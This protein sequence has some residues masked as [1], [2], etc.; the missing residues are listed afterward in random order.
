MVT[1][2]GDDMRLYLDGGL[3]FS[4]RDEYR[5]TESLVYPALGAGA[6]SV[7]GDRRRRRSRRPGAAAPAGHRDHRPG[8]TRPG[9]HRA[10]PHHHADRERRRAGRPAGKR[11][12]RRRD[13]LAARA[14][15]RRRTGQR[16]RRGDR[17]PARPGQPGDRQA[18]LARVLRTRRTCAGPRRVDGRAV[19]Q[20]VLDADGLLADGV[21]DRRSGL[22]R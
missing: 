12:D 20:S 3:Q 9:G 6:R 16:I 10:G 21:D 11:R 18:L 5:Y 14:A 17:R 4:T 1:R 15:P 8:G 13:D 7:A 22:L 19:G 2:R